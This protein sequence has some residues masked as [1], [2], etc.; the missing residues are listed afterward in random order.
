MADQRP[1]AGSRKSASYWPPVWTSQTKGT[2]LLDCYQHGPTPRKDYSPELPLEQIAKTSDKLGIWLPDGGRRTC[3]AERTKFVL[4]RAFLASRRGIS[5]QVM[6]E[7]GAQRASEMTSPSGGAPAAASPASGGSELRLAA[8]APCDC[9]HRRAWAA[10]TLPRWAP[11]GVAGRLPSRPPNA[12][13]PRGRRHRGGGTAPRPG[14]PGGLWLVASHR[15]RP[16][17]ASARGWLVLASTQPSPVGQRHAEV[18][19]AKEN[20]RRYP[21]GSLATNPGDGARE[22]ARAADEHASGAPQRHARSSN[23]SGRRRRRH[24]ETCRPETQT[25]RESAAR[26]RQRC[27]PESPKSS[28]AR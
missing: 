10:A 24:I 27:R 4:V 12:P 6:T 17:S 19:V 16:G 23:G 5:S 14:T 2:K 25:R 22:R 21:R 18:E 11:R 28:A 3:V 20:V 15:A 8:N 7:S 9:P 13:Q 26:R 1:S